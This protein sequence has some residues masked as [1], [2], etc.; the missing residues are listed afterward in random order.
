MIRARNISKSFLRDEIL[1]DV[2]LHI[3]KGAF[4][5]LLGENGAGKTTLLKMLAGIYIPDSGSLEIDEKRIV[6]IPEKCQFL[7]C[8]NLKEFAKLYAGIFYSF[9]WKRYRQ[10]LSEF[11]INENKS[12][13]SFSKGMKKQAFFLVAAS[14]NPQVMLIDELVDGVDP[15]KR[16]LIW[17]VLLDLVYEDEMTVV[18]A[19]HNIKELEGVCSHIGVIKNGKCILEENVEALREG[20][21][22]TLES[23]VNQLLGGKTYEEIFE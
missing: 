11:N 12:I 3:D 9:N 18:M 21:G 17:K 7:D 2:N 16:K 6:Y 20:K 1:C 13:D 8:I 14:V 19:S 15:V 4:Y 5:G 10:L 22:E 23:I